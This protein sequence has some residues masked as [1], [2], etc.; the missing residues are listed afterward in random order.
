MSALLNLAALTAL[1]VSVGIQWG[2]APAIAAVSAVWLLMPYNTVGHV[3][4]R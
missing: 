1:G 4:L 3:N 2:V